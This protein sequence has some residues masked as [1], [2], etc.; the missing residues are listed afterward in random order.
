MNVL[1]W[2]QSVKQQKMCWYRY[3]WFY[4]NSRECAETAEKLLNCVW[5]VGHSRECTRTADKCADMIKRC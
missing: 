3:Y 1:I 5:N 2:I 4:D